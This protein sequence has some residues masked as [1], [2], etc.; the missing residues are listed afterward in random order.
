MRSLKKKLTVICLV[1]TLPVLSAELKLPHDTP[2]AR[3]TYY[4]RYNLEFDSYWT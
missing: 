3:V 1:L 2:Q 4:A